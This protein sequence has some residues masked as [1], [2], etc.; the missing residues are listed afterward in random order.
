MF[1]S[2]KEAGE[3]LGERLRQLTLGKP[4]VLGVTRGGVVVAAE[5]AKIL[6]APLYPLVIRKISSSF[7]PEFALGAM[8]PDFQIV[9]E[10]SEI[11]E[12][13]KDQISQIRRQI[14]DRMKTLGVSD[15]ELS[16]AVRNKTAIVVDDGVATGWTLRAAV[17]YVQ[18]KQPNKVI[19]A[20]PVADESV[21]KSLQSK[22]K[23]IEF[24][25]LEQVDGLGAVGSFYEE[26]LPVSDEEVMAILRRSGD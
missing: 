22:S 7:D 26:F 19:V 12:I 15:K 6:K 5:V 23:K 10:N 9:S 25:V 2:R 13:S 17:G 24:V 21:V 1:A 14:R 11:S 18:G 8:G 20:V 4:V 16:A 3:L